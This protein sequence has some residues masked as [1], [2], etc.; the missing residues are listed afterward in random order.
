M[1][2]HSSGRCA[3]VRTGRTRRAVAAPGACKVPQTPLRTPWSADRLSGTDYFLPKD[4]L[5]VTYID[6]MPEST[7]SITSDYEVTQ[8][9]RAYHRKTTCFRTYPCT[10]I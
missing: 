10:R 4:F 2:E 1:I 6:V 3:G 5:D 7:G 8:Q 9:T